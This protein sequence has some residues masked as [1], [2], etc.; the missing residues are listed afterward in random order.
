MK[1]RNTTVLTRLGG[2]SRRPGPLQR[3]TRITLALLLVLSHP[4]WA[5]TIIVDETTCTLVDAITAANT[6]TASGGCPAG[7]GA[8]TVELTTDVTLTAVVHS[9]SAGD[10]GLPPVTSDITVE[11]SGFKIERSGGAPAFRFFVVWQNGTLSLNHVTLENG[12]STYNGGAILNA[13]TLNLTNSALSGNSSPHRGGAILNSNQMQGATVTVTNSTLSGNWADDQGGGI[14]SVYGPVTLTNSTLSGNHAD[15]LGGAIVSFLGHVTLTNSTLSGNSASINGGLYGAVW[16]GDAATVENS[17]IAN[18]PGGNCGGLIADA[19]NNFSD[20]G[21]CGPGFSPITPRVHFDPALTDNG[22]PTLT[23]ALFPGSVAINAAGDCG[24]DTDQR[25]FPRS[26]GG[27]DSGSF[28]FQANC[29]N[30]TI[31][32]FEECDD[33]NS[34]WCDGCSGTCVIEVGLVCGDGILN[35]HCEGCDDGNVMSCDGCSDN[36]VIEPGYICGDG[37]LNPD[38]GEE[39]DDGNTV[40]GD[41]CDANCII[42]FCGDGIIQVDLGEECDDGNNDDGDGCAADCTI[43]QDVPATTYR[44]MAV[45]ALLLL[46]TSTAFL[47]RRRSVP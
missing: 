43:E 7:S 32:P 3:T 41:G 9:D 26:G 20:D 14:W 25:G 11:G 6:D 35:T 22:G 33:G 13:G 12:V 4:L 40:P 31:D 47:L 34:V 15:Y 36:C 28:E 44:G 24:L 19:G 18:N 30:G 10:N 17:I 5:A 37:I 16:Y 29:G 27:C 45:A 23:H 21:T 2:G 8:D 38:C 39:C 42:E 1:P 46:V